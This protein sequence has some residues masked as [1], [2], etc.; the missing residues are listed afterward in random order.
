MFFVLTLATP[1]DK[2]GSASCRRRVCLFSK[3]DE[4]KIIPRLFLTV[5][6]FHLWIEASF[7]LLIRAKYDIKIKFS[8]WG[9]NPKIFSLTAQK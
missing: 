7:S 4:I 8:Q 3:S 9:S 5:S 1:V 6:F 2:S